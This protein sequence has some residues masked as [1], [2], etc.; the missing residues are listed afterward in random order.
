[1]VAERLPG[2]LPV[3][4]PDKAVSGHIDSL[5]TALDLTATKN[6]HPNFTL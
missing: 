5:G 4:L 1:M 2:V 6:T 3:G